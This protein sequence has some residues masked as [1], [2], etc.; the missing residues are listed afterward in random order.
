[1][2]W[3]APRAE[4][5]AKRGPKAKAL[6]KRRVMQGPPPGVIAFVGDEAVGWLQIGPRADTP[7][8]N[9]PR[10]VTAPLD[11]ADAD[12]ERIWGATCFF[13]KSSARAG[14]DDSS[15]Q[16]R[17]RVRPRQR[18]LCRRS[19]PDGRQIKRH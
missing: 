3:R 9:S 1:M 18:R 6:F 15:R 8:W 14:R 11:A 16:R 4:Y 2:Y 10:R 13:I 19:L 5:A 17:R 7:Q 12:D